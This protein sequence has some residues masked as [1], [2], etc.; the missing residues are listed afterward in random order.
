MNVLCVAEKPSISRS[1][2]NILSGGQFQTRNTRCNF[3]KNYDFDYPQARAKFTI[4]CVAGHILQHEFAQSHRTWHSCDPFQLFDAPIETQV[5]P[6]KK[7]IADNLTSEARKAHQLMIWTD[8]DREGEH[9]GVEI[10]KICRR[11]KPNIVVKRARFSAIIAQQIHHAAQHPVE[12]DYSQASAVEARITLDLRIGAAFTRMQTLTLQPL[13]Q[14]ITTVVSYGPCQFPTLGFVVSRFDQVQAFR[15]EKFWYIYLALCHNTTEIPEETPFTWGRGHLFNFPIAYAIYE[16]VLEDNMARVT[17]VTKKNTKKWKPLPLTTVELQK[18]ASRLLRLSPKKIL[19]VAEHLYQQGFLSYPRTETDQYDPQFDFTSLIAKQVV[20]PAWGA[21]AAN[22]RDGGGYSQPRRGKNNDQAHPPIHPT[23]HVGNLAGDEKRVYEFITRR[24]LACCSKDALGFETIVEV[25]YGGEDFSAKGLIILERN[26]LDVYPYDKWSGKELPDF[27]EGETFVPSVCELRDGTTT[28][29]SLLTEADLV[30]IM[31]KN[32]IGTDATIA[33]HIDTII[34]REYVVPRM[35][36]S[37]K[38]L[39]PSTFG[40]GLVNGYN[41]IGFDRSLSKPQLRRETERNM[42]AVCRGTKSKND[43]IVEAIEQ[44][45]D[46]YLK[47]KAN[48]AKV[49]SSVRTHIEGDGRPDRGNNRQGR[50][51]GRNGGNGGP[52]GGNGGN[53]G[54]PGGNGGNGGPPGGNDGGGRRGRPVTRSARNAAVPRR[55]NPPARPN[56]TAPDPGPGPGRGPDSDEELWGAVS[57]PPPDAVPELGPTRTHSSSRAPQTAPRSVPVSGPSTSAPQINCF[58]GKPTV[59]FTVKKQSENKGRRFRRCGQPKDCDFFEWA[60][61][62]PQEHKLKRSGPPDP[63]SIPAKR[64]RTGDATPRKYCR[65]DLTAVIKTVKKE[66]PNQGKLYWSCPNSQAAACDFFEWDNEE[67][68]A[69]APLTARTQSAGN[70]QT[71]E[72]FNCGQPGHWASACPTRDQRGG[73][74]RSRTAAPKPKGTRGTPG[75]QCLKCGE[76]GHYSND[77]PDPWVS[78]GGGRSSSRKASSSRGS[79]STRGTSRGRG[80]GKRTAAK[81][82]S[83]SKTGAFWAADD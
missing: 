69:A 13:F 52:P 58:C 81:P 57:P 30:G 29:P 4:T 66:G 24:F 41:D 61:E 59:E 74:R 56:R 70:Q 71:G 62:L 22:L 51:P 46:M 28:K 35:E 31:D 83:R 64:S 15:P 44:Y 21:F 27:E 5:A 82:R 39:V 54:P 8:C 42:I 80:R 68:G 33:Q 3:V 40:I 37:V 1:I 2:T 77:C 7:A 76:D 25:V 78:T 32:G 75:V 47:T 63:P 36:G 18:S 55:T 20:D 50:P 11:A 49:I 16:G 17:K 12:L 60:D 72:C 14:Q 79:G 23:A 6:D 65:C 9:I 34:N 73:L 38:Y 19:D 26:Y 67:V 48:F 10:V 43:M 53:G 45:K